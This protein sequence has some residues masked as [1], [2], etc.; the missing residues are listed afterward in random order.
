MINKNIE[1]PDDKPKEEET[2][3]TDQELKA[4]EEKESNS[5]KE[6]EEHQGNPTTKKLGKLLPNSRY[7]PPD[8]PIYSEP[9][10]I[11]FKGSTRKPNTDEE[12][13]D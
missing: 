13:S 5:E 3:K 12:K 7:L 1:V 11:I 6:D 9:P 10:G 2:K 4:E 8:D